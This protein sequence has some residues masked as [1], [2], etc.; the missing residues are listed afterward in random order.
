VITGEP[1]LPYAEE[2]A[3]THQQQIMLLEKGRG[4]KAESLHSAYTPP[5]QINLRMV[6]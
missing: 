3:T 1:L 6:Y 5:S 4:R 2:L